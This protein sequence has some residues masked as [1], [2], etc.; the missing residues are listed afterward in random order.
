MK[1]Y[2]LFALTVVVVLS[3]QVWRD[4]SVVGEV[5]HVE[6]PQHCR[7]VMS[8]APSYGGGPAELHH[9]HG[10]PPLLHPQVPSYG[11]A[12]AI[13]QLCWNKRFPG[14]PPPV[15]PPRHRPDPHLQA[16]ITAD[17]IIR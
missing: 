13:A 3:Y 16:A 5:R 2:Y 11:Q 15:P 6:S 1:L 7:L 8:G 9:G 10:G 4:P 12:A 14:L 17:R